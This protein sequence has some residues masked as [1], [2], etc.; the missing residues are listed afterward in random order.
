MDESPAPLTQ[1]VLDYL[2]AANAIEASLTVDEQRR[3]YRELILSLRGEL[4]RVESVEDVAAGTVSA[5]LY[6]PFGDERNVFV[7][8]HGGGW[9]LGDLESCDHV[10]RA[11]ANRAGCAVLSVDY[12]LAPEDPYPAGLDDCWYATNWVANRF[13]RIAVGGDSCG[14]NLAAVVALRARDARLAITLQVLVYAV[15]DWHDERYLT[16]YREWNQRRSGFAGDRF[17]IPMSTWPTPGNDRR[18][19][20]IIW[21]SCPPTEAL[22]T[23]WEVSPLRAPSVAGVAPAMIITAEHDL[24]TKEGKDYAARLAAAGVPLQVLDSPGQVHGF[25]SAF[26]VMADGRDAVERVAETIQVSFAN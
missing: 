12:R 22:R 23:H 6:R 21:D 26:N 15:L 4:E 16:F 19:N 3:A 25:F 7:W 5:R 13:D 24:F 10:A 9:I 14:G 1:E 17:L 20:S 2:A 18:R 8:F 11:L